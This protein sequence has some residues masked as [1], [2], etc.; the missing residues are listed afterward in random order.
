M[1]G[2]ALP[3]PPL[4]PIKSAD[5]E[6]WA[7]SLAAR[8]LLPELVR[9]LVHGTT[10]GIVRIDFPAGDASQRHGFDGFLVTETASAFAPKGASVWEFST[11]LE[12][13]KKAQRDFESAGGKVLP[14]NL[15]RS[16]LTF[17]FVTAQVWPNARRFEDARAA[18]PWKEVRVL[19]AS[20]LEQWLEQSPAA[21][22]WFSEQLGRS[23]LRR[24][25]DSV[26]KEWAAGTQPPTSDG[27]LRA[28]R[29]EAIERLIAWLQQAGREV[30]SSHTQV[31]HAPDL[32]EV[33]GFLHAVL[34][35]L[36]VTSER[37]RDRLVVVESDGALR[38]L[39]TERPW[40]LVLAL[41]CQLSTARIVAE[42]GH[43]VIVGTEVTQQPNAIELGRLDLGSVIVA[44]ESAGIAPYKA[45]QFAAESGGRMRELRRL[46]QAPIPPPR[47][48]L[49]P[50][51]LLG[52]WSDSFEGD[53]EIVQRMVSSQDLRALLRPE[54][55]RET[56]PLEE[57]ANVWRWRNRLGTWPKLSGTLTPEDLKAFG[58]AAIEVLGATHPKFEL[59]AGERW[60]AA[61]R[62]KP[63][64]YS[65]NLRRGIAEGVAYLGVYARDPA[66]TATAERIVASVLDAE[67]EWPT[68]AT[69]REEL[70]VLAEAAPRAFLFSVEALTERGDAIDQLLRSDSAWGFGGEPIQGVV[71]GLET[72][73]W[74][75]I[76]L[77]DVLLLLGSIAAR[78]P[79]THNR[80]PARRAL[81]S[82]LLPWYPLTNADLESRHAA[83]HQLIQRHEDEGFELLLS[84]LARAGIQAEGRRPS[85]RE[86]PVRDHGV[87]RSEYFQSMREISHVALAL[88]RQRAGRWIRLVPNLSHLDADLLPSALG[89]LEAIA[90]DLA[91]DPEREA[92]AGALRK[93]VAHHRRF[94]NAEWVMD[95]AM[96]TRLESVLDRVGP[97]DPVTRWRWLFAA[98]V[99]LPGFLAED[100]KGSQA[101][102]DEKRREAARE[103]A[104]QGTEAI[105]R[106]ASEVEF[107]SS[108]GQALVNAGTESV[109][110]EA[111]RASL[112]DRHSRARAFRKGVVG[113][114]AYGRNENPLERLDVAT[115]DPLDRAELALGLRRER[116]TW[117]LVDGW[118]EAARKHYWANVDMGFVDQPERDLALAIRNLVAAGRPLEAIDLAGPKVPATRE[119]LDAIATALEAVDGLEGQE[120]RLSGL[121][122]TV[123]E[124]MKQLRQAGDEF[125]PRLLSLEWKWF[126][127]LDSVNERPET[128]DEA[129][130]AEPESFLTVLRAAF[131]E[132][133]AGDEKEEKKAEAKAAQAYRLLSRSRRVPGTRADGI[134]DPV[135]LRAWIDGVREAM[136]GDKLA[137]VADVYVGHALANSAVGSDGLWPH[138]AI[139][140]VVQALPRPRH[141]RSGFVTAR[142]N[143]RGAVWRD[144]HGGRQ[145]R[146]LAAGY[147]QDA[148]RL[149]RRWGV[150]ASWL[151]ALAEAYDHEA[152][153]HDERRELDKA[154]G[155]ASA[156]DTDRVRSWLD[157]LESNAR[158]LFR[159]EELRAD[160]LLRRI[161]PSAALDAL[162]RE[163]RLVLPERDIYAVVPREYQRT[164]APP[165]EWFLDAWMNAT[166]RTYCLGLLSGAAVH[167]A[168]PQAPQR[169]YVLT[170][171][172]FDRVRIGATELESIP[173]PAPDRD[174]EVRNTPTGIIRIASPERTALDLVR[175]AQLVGGI[176]LVAT[177][178]E[179]LAE[180]IDPTRLQ[181]VAESY[182]TPVIQR[183]G[184]IFSEL[185][186][187]HAERLAESLESVADARDDRLPISLRSDAP[188]PG[189][190]AA[191]W[192][193]VAERP[194]EL[195]S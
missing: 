192:L 93:F 104:T 49:A 69:L 33:A 144:D 165:P 78:E 60:L 66:M 92:L 63:P 149:R 23:T 171:R 190:A 31:V 21:S 95:D 137:D 112:G 177:V 114:F 175:H 160:P 195:D 109:A 186:D 135:A 9:R 99:E 141:V 30:P 42:A 173:D 98:H 162:V 187:D 71:W 159:L 161:D 115:L 75:S 94:P 119:A 120:H 1:A 155:A 113:A 118:G 134:V 35:Q 151:D 167:V 108:L 26:W 100:W 45:Q 32:G 77:G 61:V 2:Q 27:I 14:G 168:L 24:T 91:S 164:G 84:F 7:R 97:S 73:A 52:S 5:I 139:R 40:L 82:I 136:Q 158:Y 12:V 184:W 170:S 57:V 163:K 188:P 153:W 116:E 103:L 41:G 122:W 143:Q 176:D 107:S 58:K 20:D 156:T 11:S 174:T 13:E 68:W 182:E 110:L 56:S 106:L 189:K 193:V 183:A 59:P 146:E 166:G 191:P 3:E 124:L 15:A 83:L 37:L 133:A 130:A 72:L 172:P 85:F 16:D 180:R 17:V 138:E 111:T 121:A 25:L 79:K 128:L 123:G 157:T 29:D 194:L 44:L 34:A 46:L 86:W 51:F 148:S 96:L 28:G 18:S 48:E 101:A 140:E 88:A 185:T 152:R 55:S 38:E 10:S 76:Y 74:N 64:R 47:R 4:Q 70:A 50:L 8:A 89:D 102:V 179:G 169:T 54:G 43:R 65:D 126:S 131:A 145:E 142:R 154:R 87:P 6:S 67:S 22:A 150:I 147:R 62:G 125:R 19:E 81:S 132:R 117:A 129:F 90:D 127:V 80:A 53:Q 36:P 39:E 181:R 105:L 178:L